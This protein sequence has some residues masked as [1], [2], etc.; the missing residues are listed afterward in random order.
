MSSGNHIFQNSVLGGKVAFIT[1]GGSGI[2]LRIAERFAQ[3]G[4]KVALAGRMQEKLDAPPSKRP[5]S[6]TV[7]S[8][9]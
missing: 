5:A 1:G 3:H 2:C 8:I 6:N 9:F 7:K 4:A